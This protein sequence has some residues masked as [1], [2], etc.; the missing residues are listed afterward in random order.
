MVAPSSSS[1][2][3]SSAVATAA[4]LSSHQLPPVVHSIGASIG[5][6]LAILAFYPFERIRVELQSQGEGRISI[7]KRK[8][9]GESNLGSNDNSQK[10]IE[11]TNDNQING[12]ATA[13]GV[14]KYSQMEVEREES[15]SS[16]NS[17]GGSFELVPS[18]QS[19]DA[20]SIDTSS[21][22]DNPADM[23]LVD[24][25]EDGDN[26]EIALGGQILMAEELARAK[27]VSGQ[28][29][30]TVDARES[31][32]PKSPGSKVESHEKKYLPSDES[33][34]QCFLRLHSEQT[35]YK[36][37]SHVVTTLTISNAIFFYALQVTRRSLTSVRQQDSRPIEEKHQH[38]SQRFLNCILPKSKMGNS[39]IA[40][41][42]AGAINVFLTNP[43]WVASLRIMESKMPEDN[44]QLE[45]QKSLLRVMHQIA[46]DEGISRLWNGTRT[47]LLLVANPIIQHFIYEQLRLLLMDSRRRR[48]GVRGNSNKGRRRNSRDGNAHSQALSP[49]EAFAF[50]ALAKL[51][52]T[53]LTYPLQ[54]AQVLL[55]LQRKKNQLSQPSHANGSQHRDPTKDGIGESYYEGTLDCLYKQ[56]SR[57]GLPALFKGMKAKLLQTVMTAAFTFLTNEQTLMQA[58]RIYENLG[59]KRPVPQ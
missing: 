45:K 57:G 31:R 30:P 13:T 56:F 24:G 27:S 38:S 32:G 54:L 59:P 40:S 39:L 7:T 34:I 10:Q 9:T 23:N 36:G 50:G 28:R 12:V 25:T 22:D 29:D 18:L 3:S 42:L 41:S 46:N 6:A 44:N 52:A 49:I 47:S 48:I 33:I 1:L 17:S 21:L 5:G 53:V 2:K 26:K 51:V 55:R 19:A 43:L 14:A 35:L 58:A 4:S 16:L 15:V 8:E 20:A 37:A 11:S